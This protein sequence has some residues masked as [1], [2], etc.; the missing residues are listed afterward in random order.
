MTSPGVDNEMISCTAGG[1]GNQKV[2]YEEPYMRSR[3]E[4]CPES[5]GRCASHPG[6]L[7]HKIETLLEVETSLLLHLLL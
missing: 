5:L 3:R 4:W 2:E 1:L 6:T 7:Y